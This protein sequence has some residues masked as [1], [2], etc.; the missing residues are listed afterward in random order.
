MKS[1]PNQFNYRSKIKNEIKPT[2]FII[3]IQSQYKNKI[4]TEI[5]EKAFLTKHPNTEIRFNTKIKSSMCLKKM[6]KKKK[7]GI[8]KSCEQESQAQNL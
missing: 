8:R 1:L 7:N 6:F 3:N 4:V 2:T 5:A